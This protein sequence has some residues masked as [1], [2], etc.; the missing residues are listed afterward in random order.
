MRRNILTTLGVAGALLAAG[1]AGDREAL[2]TQPSLLESPSLT[3]DATRI[4]TLIDALYPAGKSRDGARAK[5]RAIQTKM[6]QGKTADARAK[7]FDL[8]KGTLADLKAG[9]LLN[10]A[11]RLGLTTQQAVSE[12]FNRLYTCVG[13]GSAAPGDLTGALGPDG[14]VAVVVPSTTTQVVVTGDGQAGTSF[15]P[16]AVD[17]PVLVTIMLSVDQTDPLPTTLDQYGPFYDFATFPA[18]ATF[19]QPVTLGICARPTGAS[20]EAA[21]RLQLAH[22]APGGV[23]IE[24][25]A[26]APTPFL[27]CAAQA[28]LGRP[29]RTFVGAGP[30][31]WMRRLLDLGLGALGPTPLHAGGLVQEELIPIGGV[32][33]RG[34]NFGDPPTGMVDSDS[35]LVFTVQPSDAVAGATITPLVQVTVQTENGD[36][37]ASYN[38]GITVTV[39]TNPVGGTLTGGGDLVDGVGTF[40]LSI[41]RPGTGYTLVATATGIDPA[42]APTAGTSD[43]FNVIAAGPRLVFTLHPTNTA[44]GSPITPA[45]Q[46]SAVDA[47]GN[48]LVT[49]N[50]AV[51]IAIGANPSGGVLSGTI[52]SSAVGGIAVFNDL[53]IDRTGQDYTLTASAVGFAQATSAAFDITV[54]GFVSVSAAGAHTCGLAGSGKAYCWGANSAGELG[55]GT[56]VPRL[57]PAAVAMPAAV[58]FTTVVAAGSFSCGLTT[59]GGAYCWGEN[60]FGELGDGTTIDR[61]L[62]VPVALPASTPLVSLHAAGAHTCGRTAAGAVYCWGYNVHGQLGNGSTVNSSTPVAVSMPSGVASFASVMGG[63]EHTCGLTAVGEAY[64]WGNNSLG[65]LGDGTTISRSEPVLV[66]SLGGWM[67]TRVSPGGGHTCGD[68]VVTLR[69]YCW[70]WNADGQLG[71]GTTDQRTT[72]WPV[73]KPAGADAWVVVAGGTHTC[74]LPASGAPYCWGDNAYGQ[75]GDETTT[76]RTTPVPVTMPAVVTFASLGLSVSAYHSCA[77]TPAG[78][79]YCWGG[80]WAGQLGDGTTTPRATPTRVLQ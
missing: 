36:L 76:D 46:V 29:A 23:T 79:A 34:S 21:N 8:L 48:L 45:V 78:Q 3:C 71:D 72:P 12:L 26:R 31:G 75:V 53:S 62:P 77:L 2:P 9:K 28:S 20:P 39:G 64:C 69:S 63:A 60:G 11:S 57:T 73:S 6:S 66:G 17:Q 24:I 13:L 54:G 7:M 40:S 47:S 55:D 70:G 25:L 51:T 1:C 59:T 68:S 19:Q 32:T 49:F 15:P 37:I 56:T 50:E 14:G 67:L 16:G 80:N 10:T 42:F 22:P 41:D 58:V 65:Q 43:P 33:A 30:G 27:A 38:A 4:N 44:P 18:T 74:G 5:F 52:V 35:R 61:S